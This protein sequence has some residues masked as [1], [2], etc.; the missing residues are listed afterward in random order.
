MVNRTNN[1]SGQQAGSPEI[2]L[3]NNVS[4]CE[5]VPKAATLH[6]KHTAILHHTYVDKS[7]P[8]AEGA[9]SGTTG[10]ETG[11]VQERSE[12]GVQTHSPSPV[13]GRQDEAVIFDELNSYKGSPDWFDDAIEEERYEEGKSSLVTGRVLPLACFPSQE[14][15]HNETQLLFPQ[16]PDSSEQAPSSESVPLPFFWPFEY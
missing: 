10:S 11:V 14:Q 1:L 2:N 13:A 6:E 16:D 15:I 3:Q 9:V 8:K 12:E 5:K 4:V 7:M